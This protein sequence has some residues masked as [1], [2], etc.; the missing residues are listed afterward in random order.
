MVGAWNNEAGQTPD[1]FN[2][3]SLANAGGYDEQTY[4]PRGRSWFVISGY[5]GTNIYYE[6][7]MFSYSG[8]VVNVFAIT[9]PNE[10]RGLYDP[11]VEQMEDH[12]RPGSRCSS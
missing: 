8:R 11:I 9:Y 6:R 7:V 1:D 12:F 3:W 5:R 2:R 10:S 4:V